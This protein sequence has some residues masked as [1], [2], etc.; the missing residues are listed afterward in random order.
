M[1]LLLFIVYFQLELAGVN[2]EAIR[3]TMFFA[4]GLGTMVSALT[5]RSL[6]RPLW[7]LAPKNNPFL[8]AGVAAGVFLLVAAIYFPAMSQLL[9]TVPLTRSLVWISIG[10]AL[11]QGLWIEVSKWAFT[12]T[13]Q[14]A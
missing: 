6:E 8:F 13:R 2:Q 4:Y 5:F 12:R 1:S 3:T 10:C 7:Q 9:G 11:L 14:D